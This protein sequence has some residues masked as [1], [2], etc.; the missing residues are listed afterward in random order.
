VITRFGGAALFHA[1]GLFVDTVDRRRTVTAPVF[2]TT[3]S[4]YYLQRRFPASCTIGLVQS[5][6][7]TL[8]LGSSSGAGRYRPYMPPPAW[9]VVPRP[10]DAGEPF[11]AGRPVP[12]APDWAAEVE[13]AEDD[14]LPLPAAAALVALS[15]NIRIANL[16]QA[17]MDRP[18][19]ARTSKTKKDIPRHALSGRPL[20]GCPGADTKLSARL[21]TWPGSPKQAESAAI[22]LCDKTIIR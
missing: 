20:A 17:C 18:M 15:A 3:T 9:L 4:N 19:A 11:D 22:L 16:T 2:G 21:S 7:L 1:R 6:S 10:A 5:C 12:I 14:A 8:R 13:A